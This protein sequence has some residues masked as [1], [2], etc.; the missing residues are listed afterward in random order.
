MKKWN[1]G[2]PIPTAVDTLVTARAYLLHALG[3]LEKPG[4]EARDPILYGNPLSS[5]TSLSIKVILKN[6]Q[7][8][9]D[10]KCP[11]QAKYQR[12][13]ALLKEAEII[14]EEIYVES[15]KR[16]WPNTPELIRRAAAKVI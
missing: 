5:L 4:T 11:E 16:P 8:A 10:V 6:A 2:A 15:Q 9:A 13:V 12:I 14:K 7:C 1:K 3:F